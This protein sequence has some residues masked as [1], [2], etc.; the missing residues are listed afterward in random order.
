MEIKT[1]TYITIFLETEGAYFFTVTT[2]GSV[3]LYATY[4]NPA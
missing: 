3:S 2:H 1:Y 4:N